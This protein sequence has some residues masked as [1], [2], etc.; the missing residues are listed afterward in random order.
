MT[1]NFD[2]VAAKYRNA[3]SNIERLTYN[4]LFVVYSKGMQ[5]SR[6]VVHKITRRLEHSGKVEGNGYNQIT[7]GFTA[8]YANIEENVRKHFFFQPGLDVATNGIPNA[9]KIALQKT[10]S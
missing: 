3:Y 6:R 8:P 9:M 2:T 7:F 10:F 4:E 1:D 5:H